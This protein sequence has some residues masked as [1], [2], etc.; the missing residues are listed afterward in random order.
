M[1]GIGWAEFDKVRAIE[2]WARELGFRLTGTNYTHRAFALR[3]LD[4]RYPSYTRDTDIYVGDANEIQCF[5]DGLKF[6]Q[7]YHILHMKMF[8][9]ATLE[10]KEQNLRNEQLVELIKNPVSKPEDDIPF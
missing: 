7:D 4:D 9:P 8:K 1:K 5:L 10:R 3:P 6:M 2:G